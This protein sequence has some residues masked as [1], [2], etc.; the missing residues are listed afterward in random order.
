MIVAVRKSEQLR[1]QHFSKLDS[2][3]IDMAGCETDNLYS[4]GPALSVQDNPYEYVGSLIKYD[5][6]LQP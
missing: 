6:S 4:H 1:L 3:T 5:T 2:D